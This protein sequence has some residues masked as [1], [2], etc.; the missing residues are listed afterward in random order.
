MEFHLLIPLILGLSWIFV[1]LHH[2]SAFALFLRDAEVQSGA[3]VAVFTV[4]KHLS[5]VSF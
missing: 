5:I 2:I 1:S 4:P 3:V